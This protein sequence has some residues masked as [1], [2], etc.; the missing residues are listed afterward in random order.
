[1]KINRRYKNKVLLATML[2]IMLVFSACSPTAEATVENNSTEVETPLNAST[3]EDI[4]VV[5]ED[6][7][8]SIDL[9]VLEDKLENISTSILT[10]EEIDGLLFMREEEKLAQDVYL[11]LADY[12]DIQIFS[13][14]ARSEATHT[15]AV[16]QLLENN[17]IEDP[18]LSTDLGEFT[19][20][21]LQDLYDQLVAD[22]SQSLEAALRVGAAIEEIDILD[23]EEFL[24]ATE[25]ESIILVYNNLLKGSFNH[26]RAFVSNLENRAGVIY[27]PQY[28]EL[29]AYEIILNSS[30]GNGGHGNGNDGKGKGKNG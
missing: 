17:G 5:E 16:R 6:G 19:N 25:N 12:W 23:L 3:F 14:I 29:D 1:M 20:P 28:M 7:S 9:V 30:S 21:I 26:L 2:V 4:T 27:Q 10:A 24:G 15:E 11:Y 18:A 22:G 8:T 13:N